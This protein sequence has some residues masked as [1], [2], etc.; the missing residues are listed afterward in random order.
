MI[1]GQII[2]GQVVAGNA[3]I[4][5]LPGLIEKIDRLQKEIASLRPLDANT[6]GRILQRFRLDWNYHS[7]NI[8][9]N[10]Y[11]YGETKAFLLH[12]LTAGG[13]PLRDSLE[14]KGHNEVILEL[15][16]LV[17][18]H[19]PLTEHL[20][21]ELHKK[22]LGPEPYTIKAEAADGSST[23]RSVTPGRYKVE[24]NHVRTETGEVFYFIEPVAVAPEM[25]ALLEWYR[26]EEEKKE[27]HPV[28]LAALLHYRFVRIHPFDD[29][30]GRMARILMNL[31]LMKHGYPIAIV[32]TEEKETYYRALQQADGENLDAFVSY[33]AQQVINSQELWLKGARG[34]SLEDVE[35]EIA[36]LKAQLK[37]PNRKPQQSAREELIRSVTL[38]VFVPFS[39]YAKGKLRMFDDFYQ[40][41][42]TRLITSDILGKDRETNIQELNNYPLST[43][44]LKSIRIEFEWKKARDANL[45]TVSAEIGFGFIFEQAG[46]SVWEGVKPWYQK[47]FDESLS[48][49]EQNSL[50]NSSSRQL[51]EYLKIKADQAGYIV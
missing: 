39:E 6:Q 16:D 42:Y 23:S 20:I 46:Y 47:R 26:A 43:F 40:E 22:I 28:T 27:L 31:V 30:N 41:S 19:V 25:Q 37:N 14:I 45:Q 2:A 21:R 44:S 35:K 12:G 11:D 32:K 8:E 10:S 36:I 34:E 4:G 38:D 1:A 17:K 49:E 50:I 24:P 9:G 15:E 3:Y 5:V 33:I 18:N 51:L 7:N 29:G 13:K 48:N